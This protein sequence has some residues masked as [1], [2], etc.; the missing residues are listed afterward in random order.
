M[1]L[2]LILLFLPVSGN[3]LQIRA[4]EMLPAVAQQ[5]IVDVCS[6][7]FFKLKYLCVNLH[8]KMAEALMVGYFLTSGLLLLL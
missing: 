4:W 6:Y 2:T 1:G 7:I 8:F 3:K 5:L